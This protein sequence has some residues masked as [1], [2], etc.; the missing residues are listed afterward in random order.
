MEKP[1]DR[2]R[3]ENAHQAGQYVQMI[4]VGVAANEEEQPRQIAAGRA[5]THSPGKS[6]DADQGLSRDVGHG[7]PRVRNG[8]ARGQ[9]G[10]TQSL[11]LLDRFQQSLCVIQQPGALSQLNKL[12]QDRGLRS[13]GERNL[14]SVQAYKIR[15]H[16]VTVAY[17]AIPPRAHGTFDGYQTRFVQSVHLLLKPFRYTS[18]VESPLSRKLVSRELAS[19]CETPYLT[20]IN[21]DVLGEFFKTHRTIRHRSCPTPYA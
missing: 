21:A 3:V 2:W 19:I 8:N 12:P 15:N 17:A 20:L 1:V 18:P 13:C 10:G 7:L 14:D 4:P 11:A 6:C 9:R 16:T 5:E